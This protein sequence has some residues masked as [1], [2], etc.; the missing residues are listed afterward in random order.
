[1]IMA[2][3]YDRPTISGSS[4]AISVQTVT[5]LIE[6][7]VLNLSACRTTPL[8]GLPTDAYVDIII[9]IMTPRRETHQTH[10][11]ACEGLRALSQYC[12]IIIH[13]S[14]SCAYTL[15]RG[16]VT[17]I[18]IIIVIIIIIMITKSYFNFY[19]QLPTAVA[20]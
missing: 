14:L 1:M 12:Y 4:R 13:I 2:V 9:Y 19:F 10:P 18:I 6:G 7:R 20:V 8:G 11:R 17:F 5:R 16:D 3:D 15:H